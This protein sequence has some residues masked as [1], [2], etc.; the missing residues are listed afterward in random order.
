MKKVL[1][2]AVAM[3]MCA[4]LASAQS[5][6]HIGVYSDSPGYSDCNLVPALY[7]PNNVYVVHTMLPEANTATFRIQDDWASASIIRGAPVINGLTLGDLFTGITVT[8][9]GCQALPYLIATI[10]YTPIAATPECFYALEVLPSPTV[11]S[12]QIEIVLCDGSTTVFAT[13][14]KLTVNGNET[15]P[16]LEVATQETNW[17]KIKALYQ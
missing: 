2:L 9:G 14:G 11:G 5:G 7:A 15:C 10:P 4:S 3:V 6:G 12:G 16:C 1:I 17:S 13:G 8:Y